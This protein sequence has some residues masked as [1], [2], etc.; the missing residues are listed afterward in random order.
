[1]QISYNIIEKLYD[2]CGIV[3][4]L[5]ISGCNIKTLFLINLVNSK[6][7]YANIGAKINEIL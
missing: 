6:L 2:L 3:S 7:K 1:M 5:T 4:L